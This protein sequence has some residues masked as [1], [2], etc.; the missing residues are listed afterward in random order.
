MKL[1]LWLQGY[2]LLTQT[3]DNP[4]SFK[5]LFFHFCTLMGWV[6]HHEFD[7]PLS[8]NNLLIIPLKLKLVAFFLSSPFICYWHSQ[9]FFLTSLLT[10]SQCEWLIECTCTQMKCQCYPKLR[11]DI[12]CILEAPNHT[13]TPLLP[14]NAH[15]IQII[16]FTQCH[17]KFPYKLSHKTSQIRPLN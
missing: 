2:D 4:S 3:I 12:L 14:S 8:P 6:T 7:S 9:L 1:T 17:D 15:T 5:I 13:P 11:P 16:E 10:C